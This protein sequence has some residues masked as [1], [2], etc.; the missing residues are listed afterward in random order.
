MLVMASRNTIRD[1]M[2]ESYYHVYNRGV[3]KRK[4]F[5]E[6]K[7][8][9]VFLN[10]LKR[11]LGRQVSKDRYGRE[12]E[13][14][15]AHLELLAFCL[16]PNHFHLLIY[17]DD[18]PEAVTGLLRSICTAYTRY[19]NQKYKRVGHLFQDRFKASRIENDSY[20]EHISRYIHLNPHQ[21]ETYAWSSLPY[22]LIQKQAD[23]VRPDRIKELFENDNY[24]LFVQDYK[25]HKTMLDEIK[26]ELANT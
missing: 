6:D 21:P 15:F 9:M 8:Y 4:I 11:Y 24:L 7:D 20:L 5:L 23:W 13:N 10:L 18:D 19:F 14:Y 16:M 22:Y 17:Q 25:A 12:Y 2:T 3:N 26:H 1:H